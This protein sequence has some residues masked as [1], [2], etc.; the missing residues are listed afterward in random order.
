[1]NK[2]VLYLFLYKPFYFYILVY[3]S[4]QQCDQNVTKLTEIS[5]CSSVVGGGDTNNGSCSCDN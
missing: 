3:H 5:K 2:F 1:M 4:N